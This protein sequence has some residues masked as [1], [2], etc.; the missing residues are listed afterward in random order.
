MSIY[1]EQI[2]RDIDFILDEIEEGHTWFYPQGYQHKTSSEEMV[3]KVG[4]EG[5]NLKSQ[6]TKL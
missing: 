3:I 6:R 2:L 1:R 5:K 4:V